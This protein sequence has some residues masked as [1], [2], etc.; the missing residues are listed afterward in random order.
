[1]LTKHLM[2]TLIMFWLSRVQ[3]RQLQREGVMK[4][5]PLIEIEIWSSKNKYCKLEI[6]TEDEQYFLLDQQYN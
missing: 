2:L 6:E 5:S 4:D 3:H 1:M